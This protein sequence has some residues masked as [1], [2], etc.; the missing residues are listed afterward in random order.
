VVA[1]SSQRVIEVSV[2]GNN[3][4]PF[5]SRDFPYVLIQRVVL[6]WQIERMNGIMASVQEKSL[7]VGGN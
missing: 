3:N 6:H 5:F 7:S 2:F 1:D 4:T